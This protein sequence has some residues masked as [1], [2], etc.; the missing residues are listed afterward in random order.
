M[1]WFEPFV[2]LRGSEDVQP[3][4]RPVRAGGRKLKHLLGLGDLPCLFYEMQALVALQ[5]Q[6]FM[7]FPPRRKPAA[8]NLDAVLRQIQDAAG[9]SSH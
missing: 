2:K 3:P 5:I 1:C 8:F 4:Q 9:S 7:Q 6:A